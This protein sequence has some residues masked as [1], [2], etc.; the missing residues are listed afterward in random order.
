MPLPPH[1]H[2]LYALNYLNP[3]LIGKYENK[4]HQIFMNKNNPNALITEKTWKITE[5]I[6]L[7][8]NISIF[9]FRTEDFVVKNYIPGVEWMGKHFKVI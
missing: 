9:R 5:K 3:R 4:S 1:K 6:D 7:S 8:I 2:S